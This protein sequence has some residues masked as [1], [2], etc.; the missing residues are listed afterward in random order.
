LSPIFACWTDSYADT[1]FRYLR[2][3]KLCIQLYI[4]TVDGL[5]FVSVLDLNMGFWTILLDKKVNDLQ[6]SSSPGSSILTNAL[7]WDYLL[8]PI[9]IKT[10]CPQSFLTWKT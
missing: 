9:S 1:H 3:K 6:Q 2:F 10:K 7:R 4:N 8:A 5:T